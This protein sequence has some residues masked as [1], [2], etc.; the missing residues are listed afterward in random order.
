MDRCQHL[1]RIP[2]GQARARQGGWAGFT[3]L[4]LCLPLLSPRPAAQEQEPSPPPPAAGAQEPHRETLATLAE[5]AGRIAAGRVKLARLRLRLEEKPPAPEREQLEKGIAA[6]NQEIEAAKRDFETV[7]TGLDPRRL[8]G[9]GGERHSLSGELEELLRPLIQELKRA[10]EGPRVIDRLRREAAD[11]QRRAALAER[12][13]A[14]LESLARAAGEDPVKAQLEESLEGWR[15]QRQVLATRAR[16]ADYKLESQLRRR[17]SLFE[18]TGSLAADFFRTRG[19]NLLLSLGSFL[20]VFFGLRLL[21]HR[22]I[23][24]RRRKPATLAS[25]LT[26][27][28]FYSLAFAA[29]LAA[30]L[31]VLY[32]AGDWVLL[33]LA[34]ILLVGLAWTARQAFTR[35]L[36]DI[37][38]LLNLGPVREKELLLLEGIPWQVQSLNLYTY[39]RNPALTG[40]RIRLPLRALREMRSRPCGPEEL[41]FPCRAGDWVLLGDGRRGRVAHQSP[42]LV[43]LVELGGSRVTY[44]TADFLGL[45]PRN[46]STGFRLDV[47]FGIDYRHQ[48]RCTDTV[49]SRM[50]ERLEEGLAARVE[51]EKI[52][53]LKVE[54]KEA[55]TSSLD[56]AALVD[57]DGD[58]ARRSEE[59]GRAV[60]RILVETCNEQGW[61]IPFTQVTLHRAEEEGEGG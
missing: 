23:T 59:L 30:A 42:E 53:S 60:Q 44:P 27:V 58:L 50:R 52:H 10:T 51:M 46:L 1:S 29:A 54:F 39:L 32:A 43:Q 22:T 11:L 18:S 16:V 56:Y 15:Q 21:Y 4:L 6:V 31:L 3:L 19:L 34:L 61:T 17:Q 20:L 5:L 55:G 2:T 49:P 35:F 40:G 26:R 12:A 28:L 25:R 36:E 38:M 24:K 13:V 47:T 33:G 41:W 45:H 57:C 37:R 9:E 8:Q 7:A 48:A 14:R